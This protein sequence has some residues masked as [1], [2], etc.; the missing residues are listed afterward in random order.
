MANPSEAAAESAGVEEASIT[1]DID[2]E[3]KQ[4][5]WYLP[6]CEYCCVPSCVICTFL[7]RNIRI[8]DEFW[9]SANMELA[10]TLC[11]VGHG[12]GQ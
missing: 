8:Y 6:S 12:G 2:P 11:L 7:H 10:L 5:R 1:F 3:V 9:S 4:R